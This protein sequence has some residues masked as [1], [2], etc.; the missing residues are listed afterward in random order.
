MIAGGVQNPQTLHASGAPKASRRF[1]TIE[2]KTDYFAHILIYEMDTT[3]KESMANNVEGV[4][5]VLIEQCEKRLSEL[6]LNGRAILNVKTIVAKDGVND[7][8]E[9][10]YG[11]SETAQVNAAMDLAIREKD[12]KMCLWL[13]EDYEKLVSFKNKLLMFILSKSL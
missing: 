8:V 9:V 2:I 3:I 7:Y 11:Q 5:Y 4:E 1:A 10:I 13:L 6:K 12:C